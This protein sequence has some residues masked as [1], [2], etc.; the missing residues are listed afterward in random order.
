[1]QITTFSF[2][3]V[4]SHLLTTTKLHLF[5]KCFYLHSNKKKSIDKHARKWCRRAASSPSSLLCLFGVL[6][7]C[8][9]EICE[10]EVID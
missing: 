3:S 2:L 7:L 4:F 5:A 1:L 8:N 6:T 9:E 10:R